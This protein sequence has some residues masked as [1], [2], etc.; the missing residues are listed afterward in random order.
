MNSFKVKKSKLFLTLF[1]ILIILYFSIPKI[2]I[3]SIDIFG[4]RPLDLFSVFIFLIIILNKFPYTFKLKSFFLVTV[5]FTINTVISCFYNGIIGLVYE[6][7]LFQY[8]IVGLA[9]SIVMLS[10]YKKLFLQILITIQIFISGL[11]SLLLFPNIDPAR[12]SYYGHTFSGSFGTPAELSYF[13]IA[14]IGFYA[15]MNF[16]KRIFFSALL[17]FNSVIFPPLAFIALSF[18]KT[19]SFFSQRFIFI[20]SYF[21]LLFLVLYLIGLDLF[22]DLALNPINDNEGLQKGGL[23]PDN[24]EVSNEEKSLLMRVK[25]FFGVYYYMYS[26]NVIL[27]LGCG[28]GCGHGAIDSGLIR[29]LLEFGVFGFILFFY[30]VK[31][32]PIIPLALIIILNFIFD[33]LWSST[34]A[35]VILSYLFIN[36]NVIR[37]SDVYN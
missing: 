1:I 4:I 16:I 3:V 19:I 32:I 12:G 24:F 22:L 28:Y 13:L 27:F 23:I 31:K 33:G 10:E 9:I 17:S 14:F 11:Q 21:L 30:L 2:N 5:F 7:R 15:S 35:P 25:K 26:D 6:I 34:V 20:T 8:A 29:L 18:T 37:K 36:F